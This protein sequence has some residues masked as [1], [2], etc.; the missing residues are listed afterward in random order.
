VIDKL[1]SE[2]T[3]LGTETA[4]RSGVKRTVFYVQPLIARY[5]VEVVDALGRLFKVKVFASSDGVEVRGFSRENPECEEFIETGVVHLLSKRIK[6][7]TKVLWRIVRER[8]SA[9]LIFADVTYLSLWLALVA[10]RVL[11]VPIV[12][13][14]QGLYRHVKSGLARTLCYRMAVALSTQ[15]V[16]Y[17]E[18]SRRS[19][20]RIGCSGS[21]LVVASNSLTV[22]QTVDP[23]EKTGTEEGVLF[24]GRLREGSNVEGLIEAVEKLRREGYSIVL[25]LVGGGEH[26]DRLQRTYAHRA[27]LIW[28]GAVFDDNEIATISRECRIGC[29]PGAAGLSVVHMFGL[30]LPPLVHDQ[31]PL[32]MGPEPE[33]VET[34]RTGFLYAR[35]GGVEALATSLREIWALPPEA[36]RETATGAFSKYQRLNSPTLG[37]RLAEVVYKVIER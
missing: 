32:H 20:E 16:C 31:L 22:A 5:R 29:Y 1:M 6:I 30:S 8:P 24:L 4:N 23:S 25:H 18:A 7:Q 12:I 33:Y 10:G 36:I 21:K 28:H 27:H 34:S 9:V 35:E 19:L 26:G 2:K 37:Q 15:Y 3:S 14:G 11:R 17:S 13:H